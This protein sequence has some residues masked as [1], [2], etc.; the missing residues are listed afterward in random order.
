[1][2]ILEEKSF[3]EQE[4]IVSKIADINHIYNIEIIEK[5]A[6][7]L[8]FNY[9]K[10]TFYLI[11]FSLIEYISNKNILDANNMLK[12]I[13]EILFPNKNSFY[14]IKEIYI[15]FENIYIHLGFD[16]DI[17]EHLGYIESLNFN[18]YLNYIDNDFEK[19]FLLLIKKCC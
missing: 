16:I 15:F 5:N 3:R 1:M 14:F 8:R 13:N 10:L 4:K 18:E 19:D 12:K 9:Q 7:I 17:K 11:A 2:T 6:N